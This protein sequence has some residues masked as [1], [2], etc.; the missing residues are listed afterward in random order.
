MPTHRTCNFQPDFRFI[1]YLH[2]FIW[3]I[4]VWTSCVV[5]V[6]NKS[7]VIQYRK[8]SWLLNLT[9]GYDCQFKNQHYISLTCLICSVFVRQ[10]NDCVLVKVFI[11]VK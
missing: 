2:R 5:C 8:G 6:G 7:L 3:P 10:V 11:I 9:S 4:E 1:C